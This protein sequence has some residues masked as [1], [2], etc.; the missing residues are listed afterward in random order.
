MAEF[1][2]HNWEV[3]LSIHSSHWSLTVSSKD[4][5]TWKMTSSL[6]SK[7]VSLL[8]KWQTHMFTTKTTMQKDI[9]NTHTTKTVHTHYSVVDWAVVCMH[10]APQFQSAISMG[11]GLL[12]NA[13]WCQLWDCKVLLT[14]VSTAVSSALVGIEL[15][16]P[17]CLDWCAVRW[18]CVSAVMSWRQ[19]LAS[20]CSWIYWQFNP[21]H[22]A[23][24]SCFRSLVL[25][26]SWLAII[27]IFFL[28]YLKF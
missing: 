14:R 4:S 9:K 21:T 8:Y 28:N 5:K 20:I 1:Q 23:I 26:V 2:T 18:L 3:L 24:I 22:A 6:S 25:S 10:P 12:D 15:M 7:L 11:S 17:V 13:L 16:M 19:T 27:I